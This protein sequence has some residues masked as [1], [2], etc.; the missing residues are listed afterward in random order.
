MW[1]TIVFYL[2]VLLAI[3]VLLRSV[4]LPYKLYRYY[5]KQF[6][7]KKYR[8]YNVP[9]IPFIAPSIINTFHETKKYKDGFYSAK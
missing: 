9:F 4:L 3:W 7:D 5:K 2:F 8:S 6:Q 1:T